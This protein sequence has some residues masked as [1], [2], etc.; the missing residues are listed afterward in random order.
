MT[1]VPASD[2]ISQ[3]PGSGAPTVEIAIAGQGMS[4]VEP[5]S[6]QQDTAELPAGR[7]FHAIC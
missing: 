2:S 5:R 4:D 1:E 3:A 7:L 6:G